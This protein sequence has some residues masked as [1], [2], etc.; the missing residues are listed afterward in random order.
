MKVIDAGKP[1]ESDK[2]NSRGAQDRVRNIDAK[3]LLNEILREQN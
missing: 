2:I 1:I 3:E